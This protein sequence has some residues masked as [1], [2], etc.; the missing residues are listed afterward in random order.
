M[1][2]FDRVGEVALL[3]E[4]QIADTEGGGKRFK[5]RRFKIKK[6]KNTRWGVDYIQVLLPSTKVADLE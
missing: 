4:I 3:S 1:S 6:G 5:K 2:R